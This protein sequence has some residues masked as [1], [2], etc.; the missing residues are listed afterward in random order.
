MEE[1][2]STN[3]S[4]VDMLAILYALV[5]EP[6]NNETFFGLSKSCVSSRS[7]AKNNTHS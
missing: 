7:T 2:S 1:Y 4:Q 6:H 5:Y 3:K